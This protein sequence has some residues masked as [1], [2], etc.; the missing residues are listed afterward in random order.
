MFERKKQRYWP[1]KALPIPR[2]DCDTKGSVNA[3][4]VKLE[5]SNH[6]ITAY[7]EGE[8]DHHSAKLIREE[9][10]AEI[11]KSM[12]NLLILDFRD[13]TFMDSSGIGILLG[14]Y[15]KLSQSGCAMEIK[16]ARE[17]IDKIIK[18]AGLY[19]ITRKR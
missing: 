6:V 3:V 4:S 11:Q 12:A 7:L 15:K 14:R 10:D 5:S 19:Q 8:L 1:Q 17:G 16:G 18:M 2:I 9:I 13:V